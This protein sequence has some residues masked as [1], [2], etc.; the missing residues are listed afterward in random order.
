[1]TSGMETTGM[2]AAAAVSFSTLQRWAA[3]VLSVAIAGSAVAASAPAPGQ[4]APSAYATSWDEYMALK[5]KAGGGKK[6]TPLTLPDWS[7]VWRRPNPVDQTDRDFVLTPKYLADYQRKRANIAKGIEWDRLS[8]CLPV[9]MPRWLY[10]PFIREFVPTPNQTWLLYEQLSEVRRV[11]TDGRGHPPEATAVAQWQGDSVGFWDGDTL[12]IHTAQLKAG[13]YWRGSPEHSFNATTVERWR[14]VDPLTIRVELTVYD[15]DSLQRPWHGQIT[16]SK[17]SDP[18]VRMNFTSCEEGNNVVQTP[19][20]GSDFILPG[21][22]GY[23]DP[24]TFGI[25]EVALDSLPQ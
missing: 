23:R 12:V 5:Q 15:P 20:G 9:G 22:P 2:A 24:T 4:A 21:E 6:H 14:K 18:D 3:V 19:E 17:L 13:E 7:G 25:P 10:D 1:M 8:W 16:Y 11:Y